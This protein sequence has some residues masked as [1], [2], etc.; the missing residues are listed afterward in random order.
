MTTARKQMGR[1]SLL[2]HN[3]C[4]R[5]Y[6]K[7][8]LCSVR[9]TSQKWAFTGAEIAREG[10]KGTLEKSQETVRPNSILHK[11]QLCFQTSQDM[12]MFLS[13]LFVLWDAYYKSTLI[14]NGIWG[15]EEARQTVTIIISICCS[16]TSWDWAPG[17]PSQ[18]PLEPT[19]LSVGE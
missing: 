10:P 8:S 12:E 9:G 11:Q 4:R 6:R 14:T 16:P 2:Q 5:I 1:V 18:R 17:L 3:V 15:Q 13:L 19:A 7:R